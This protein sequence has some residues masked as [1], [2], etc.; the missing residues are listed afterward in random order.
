MKDIFDFTYVQADSFRSTNTKMQIVFFSG[1]CSQHGDKL[2][3][4][5][6]GKKMDRKENCFPWTVY[7]T[8]TQF[9]FADNLDFVPVCR[10]TD[11]NSKRWI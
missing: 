6:N 4:A 2:Y 5:D 3:S 8:G 7:N 9:P 11:S 10:Q 1:D